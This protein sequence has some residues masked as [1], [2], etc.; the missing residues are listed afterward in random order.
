MVETASLSSLPSSLSLP[1]S[2]PPSSLIH[3]QD[4]TLELEQKKSWWRLLLRLLHSS[5]LGSARLHA[6][7]AQCPR[8]AVRRAGGAARGVAYLHLR[9]LPTHRP[10]GGGPMAP[11]P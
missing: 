2:G 6:G 4:Q 11:D 1:P 5:E 10:N 9:C 3:R 7:A 8:G